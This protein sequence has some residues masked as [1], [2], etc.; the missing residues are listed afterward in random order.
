MIVSLFNRELS[1]L[2]DVCIEYY[3][4]MNESEDTHD[5]TQYMLETGLGSAI[6]KLGK[7]RNIAS[8]YQ[9]CKTISSKYPSFEEW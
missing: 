4:M 9:H 6:R 2:L 1:L 3:D 5:Y 7:G 8:V